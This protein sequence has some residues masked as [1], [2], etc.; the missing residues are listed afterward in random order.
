MVNAKLPEYEQN[1]DIFSYIG[2]EWNQNTD[3]TSRNFDRFEAKI[4]FQPY[5]IGAGLLSNITNESDVEKII[6]S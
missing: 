4:K 6:S 1:Q 5:E 2:Y 3:K